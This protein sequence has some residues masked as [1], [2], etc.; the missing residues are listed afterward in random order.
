MTAQEAIRQAVL[1]DGY[2]GPL[3][4]AGNSD[5]NRA[6][7]I[8]VGPLVQNA[9]LPAMTF[10]ITFV[11]AVRTMQGDSNLQRG[12][13]M[14]TCWSYLSWQAQDMA[15]VLKRVMARL[16]LAGGSSFPILVAMD[17]PGMEPETEP[18]IFKRYVDFDA[19]FIQELSSLSSA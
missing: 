16:N 11:P 6:D 2:L 8:Y 3:L 7:R 18:P 5:G 15:T 12:R 4:G 19:M 17:R 1:A 10:D 9:I 14:F 13:F